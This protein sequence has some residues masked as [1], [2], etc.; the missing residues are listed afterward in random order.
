MVIRYYSVKIDKVEELRDALLT[1]NGYSRMSKGRSMAGGRPR[2]TKV[3]IR[4]MAPGTLR[5]GTPNN[6]WLYRLTLTAINTNGFL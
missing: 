3:R 4:F 2:Q 6:S 5:V 1:V